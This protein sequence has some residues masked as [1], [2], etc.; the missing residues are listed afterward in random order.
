M[1]QPGDVLASA[2][3]YMPGKGVYEDNG[4]LIAGVCGTVKEDT[5]NMIISIQPS[6]SVPVEF[7]EGDKIFGKIQSVRDSMVSVEVIKI[8]GVKRSIGNYT[9]GTL[10]IAK[11][12]RD[13]VSNVRELYQVN[14]LIQATVIKAKPAIE[15][16]TSHD[17][18]GVVYAKCDVTHEDLK[19][20]DGKLWSEE[21][22]KVVNRKISKQYGKIQ[23]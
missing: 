17:D 22:R 20:V 11:M 2:M 8:K 13:F 15:L 5:E 12:S 14:D 16:T 9:V 21:L 1:K 4:E 10:H 7:K 19:V 23:V 18:D 3:E 6:V